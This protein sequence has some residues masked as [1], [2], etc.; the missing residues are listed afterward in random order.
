VLD[1][2][3]CLIPLELVHPLGGDDMV[4]L[5]QVCEVPSMI[6]LDRVD[7]LLHLPSDT[8]CFAQPRRRSIAPPCS[9]GATRHPSFMPRDQALARLYPGGCRRSSSGRA[10]SCAP[11]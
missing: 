8:L 11:H 3:P 7:L 5:R 1:D 10:T 2:L 6:M 4:S 9:S